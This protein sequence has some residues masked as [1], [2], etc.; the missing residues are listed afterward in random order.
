ME[1][2]KLDIKIE[3]KDTEKNGLLLDKNNIDLNNE[4]NVEYKQQNEND[5]ID[6]KGI[7]A[8]KYKVVTFLNTHE[9]TAFA[10]G[11]GFLVGAFLLAKHFIKRK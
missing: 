3:K 11:G 9:Y 6:R 8:I 10:I 4:D 1:Q 2:E 7:K 5:L